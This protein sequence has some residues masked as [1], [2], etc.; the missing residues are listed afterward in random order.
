M[1]LILIAYAPCVDAAAARKNVLRLLRKRR[2][3]DF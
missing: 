1:Q 2:Y 3:A